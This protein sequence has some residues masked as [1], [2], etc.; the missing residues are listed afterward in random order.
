MLETLLVITLV[1]TAALTAL[2]FGYRWTPKVEEPELP[3]EIPVERER[4]FTVVFSTEL[5]ASARDCFLALPKKDGETVE[6]YEDDVRR[7]VR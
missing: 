5:G 2:L 6:F 1:N 4:P 7:G 3:Q